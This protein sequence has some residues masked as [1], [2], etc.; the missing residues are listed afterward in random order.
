VR[1]GAYTY[2]LMH[3]PGAPAGAIVDKPHAFTYA[4]IWLTLNTFISLIG[5]LVYVAG[6]FKFSEA[7]AEK[8]QHDVIDEPEDVDLKDVDR[9]DHDST[10]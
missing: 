10:V 7:E 9:K 4:I 2:F 1:E 6:H 5:G 8:L 3:C